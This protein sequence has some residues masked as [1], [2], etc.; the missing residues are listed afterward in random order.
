MAIGF[1]G[2]DVC[3][4]K[5]SEVNEYIS[6]MS[7]EIERTKHEIERSKR[8]SKKQRH[9][10][11]ERAAAA[12]RALAE[13]EGKLRDDEELINSLS[14]YIKKSA[15]EYGIDIDF[16]SGGERSAEICGLIDDVMRCFSEREMS[17]RAE[18][19]EKIRKGEAAADEFIT[20]M[21]CAADKLKAQIGGVTDFSGR[22]E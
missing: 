16:P 6:K 11:E 18:A 21:K 4:Y 10:L 22:A 13:C 8:E 17:V 19:D 20:D 12:E 15:A 5:K 2:T 1:F 7:G 3:G 9:M 14:A